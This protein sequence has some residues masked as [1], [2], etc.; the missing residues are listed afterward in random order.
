MILK[1]IATPIAFE[2][3]LQKEKCDKFKYVIYTCVFV[4]I[5]CMILVSWGTLEEAVWTY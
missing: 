3:V 2:E 1:L 4:H 5:I